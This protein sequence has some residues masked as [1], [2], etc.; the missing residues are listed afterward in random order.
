MRSIFS[1]L[2]AIFSLGAPVAAA[3]PELPPT[4]AGK[5]LAG[6]LDAMNSGNKDKLEAFVKAHQPDRPDA[7][8]RML[9]LRWNIGGLDLYSIESSE[10]LSIQAVMRERD[11]VGRYDRMSVTVSDAEPAVITK[12]TLALIPPP[13]GAPVPERLTQ[14]A[15]VAAWKGEIDKAASNGKF[16]G[17]WLWAKNGK[18]ISS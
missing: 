14:P 17:V 4:P 11:E 1:V 16:S 3:P 8:D 18:T 7:I 15:A 5:V 13:A 2:L 10:A 6:Y 9:D 12:V